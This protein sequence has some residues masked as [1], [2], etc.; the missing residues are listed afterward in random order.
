MMVSRDG[1]WGILIGATIGTLF[2][3]PAHGSAQGFSRGVVRGSLFPVTVGGP[4]SLRRAG[5]RGERNLRS[6]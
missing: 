1:A 2:L 4:D 6:G 3:V 5:A